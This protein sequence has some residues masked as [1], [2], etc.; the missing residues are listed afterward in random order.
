MSLR[1]AINAFCVW[2][3]KAR[4]LVDLIGVVGI[5]VTAVIAF[6]LPGGVDDR[7]R[8][9]G[10]I[11][12]LLGIVTVAFGLHTRRRLFNRPGF[13]DE[14]HALKAQFPWPRRTQPI[15]VGAAAIVEA[16]L[17]FKIT[18]RRAGDS[19]EDR[20]AALEEDLKTLRGEQAETSKELQQE[21]T[22]RSEALSLERQSREA[23]LREIETRLDTLG[24]GGL[25]LER[26]GLVW[27]FL[28]VL[29]G[30]IPSEIAKWICWAAAI[31]GGD[32]G[33]PSWT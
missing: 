12:Q 1:P 23:A 17:T 2:V 15:A 24:A 5:V 30:T 33:A 28:G 20:L 27:L 7:V 22:K 32:A 3:L 16:S 21:R 25:H 31:C 26:T 18:A 29:L 14:L 4:R 9:A 13:M 8:Y 6:L 19:V 10:L 11:L